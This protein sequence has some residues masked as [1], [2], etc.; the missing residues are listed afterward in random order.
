MNANR[1]LEVSRNER[2]TMPIETECLLTCCTIHCSHEPGF[3]DLYLQIV[4]HDGQRIKNVELLIAP[5]DAMNIARHVHSLN[6][7]AWAEGSR[8]LDADTDESKPSWIESQ[9]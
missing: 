8:P 9:A 2:R 1:Q 7:Q 6:R 5:A 3:R 4:G